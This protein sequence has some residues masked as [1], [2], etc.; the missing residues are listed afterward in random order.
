MA[1]LQEQAGLP[2]APELRRETLLVV[3]EMGGKATRAEII[4]TAAD[5][6]GLTEAQRA[7][8]TPSGRMSVVSNRVGL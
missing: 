8:S 3:R 4:E 7:V 5:R 6:L 2:P 1:S